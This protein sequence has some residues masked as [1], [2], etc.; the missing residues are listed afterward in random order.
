MSLGEI[1]I[2]ILIG[3]VIAFSGR[4]LVRAIRT[5]RIGFPGGSIHSRTARPRDYW[6]AF[7]FEAAIL[8]I[9]SAMLVRQFA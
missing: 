7:A 3:A 5:G 1:L 6:A 4:N 9:L 2:P 8:L